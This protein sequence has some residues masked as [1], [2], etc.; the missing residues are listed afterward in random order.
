MLRR[1]RNDDKSYMLEWMSNDAIKNCFCFDSSKTTEQAVTQFI[2]ESFTFKNRHY[3]IIDENDEYMGTVSLKK[4][5]DIPNTAEFAIVLREKAM[6]KGYGKSAIKDI[7]NI[8]FNELKLHTV[9]LSV[10]K[11]NSRAI[12][13]Y[14]K[15]GFTIREDYKKCQSINDSKLDLFYFSISKKQMESILYSEL[16]FPQK[17]D[18]RGHLVVIEGNIDIP[19]DIKRIFYI[20]GSDKTTIRGCHANRKSEFV[21]IN[22]A[23]SSKVKFYDGKREDIVNLDRPHKGVFIPKMIWKEMYDFSEDAVL[24]VLASEHYDPEEYVR[25]FDEYLKEMNMENGDE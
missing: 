1:L 4:I 23:G 25:N 22:L 24:L 12:K 8:A 10:L 7:L 3:A 17:G 15:M 18:D 2:N 16:S 5:N 6:G 13:L 14:Q 11:N 19:F 9:Y 21:L 20:F